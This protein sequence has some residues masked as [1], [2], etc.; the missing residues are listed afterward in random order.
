MNKK[1]KRTIIIIY[2][3]FFSINLRS[4]SK[5]IMYCNE[6]DYEI[7][8]KKDFITNIILPKNEEISAVVCPDQ[9]DW[10]VNF[11]YNFIVIIPKRKNRITNVTIIT[12][13][14]KLYV[15]K[16]NENGKEFLEKVYIREC[17]KDLKKVYRKLLKEKIKENKYMEKREKEKKYKIKDKYFKIE[18]VWDDGIFTYIFLPKSQIRPAVFLS[19]KRKKKYEPLKNIN[20]NDSIVIHKILEKKEYFIFKYGNKKSYIRR[21]R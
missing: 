10:V 13:Q 4:E 3:L 15:F 8:C 12:K 18:K 20:R 21:I 5:N 6:K 17:I 19:K 9:M 11:K 14:K 1:L 16:L 2:I 7:N